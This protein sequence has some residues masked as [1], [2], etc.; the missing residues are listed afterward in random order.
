M[1]YNLNEPFPL[2]KFIDHV[3]QKAK[4]T[5]I[6]NTYFSQLDWSVCAVGNFV[7]CK[8]GMSVLKFQ[9]EYARVS[10][11]FIPQNAPCRQL[12]DH[13][14]AAHDSATG[15]TKEL[16]LKLSE[17]DF[18][19]YGQLQKWLIEHNMLPQTYCFMR[20]VTVQGR[21]VW[22]QCYFPED[23][24]GSQ[25]VAISRDSDDPRY[26]EMFEKLGK[27]WPE[28]HYEVRVIGEVS[29]NNTSIQ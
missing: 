12:S 21:I 9:K 29:C 28:E 18:A 13:I 25:D 1:S 15:D 6:R 7:R 4:K 3:F 10:P 16:Y 27:L 23:A 26:A 24:T 17:G 22:Y 19:N 5:K 11:L 8:M 20:R 2:Q 14:K